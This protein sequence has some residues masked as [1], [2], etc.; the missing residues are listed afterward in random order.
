MPRKNKKTRVE[1]ATKKSKGAFETS[2]EE[3]HLIDIDDFAEELKE[4]S[5]DP[6]E[7][8]LRIID[9]GKALTGLFLYEYEFDMAYRI[10]RAVVTQE[11]GTITI[12]V[13][14]QA[15]KTE[16]M[17]FCLDTLTV[18]LPRM[19]LFI[20]DF[21]DFK[22]GLMCGLFAPQS[23]QVANSLNRCLMR[24]GSENAEAVLGDPDI[25]TGLTSNVRYNLSNGSFIRGQTANVNSKVESQTYH[26][27]VIE[28][29]QDCDDFL[30]QKSIEPMVTATNGLI[31]KVGTTG[32]R[33]SD[34]FLEIQENIKQ[35]RKIKD[36]RMKLHYEYDYKRVMKDKRTQYSIDKKRFH[37]NY[38]KDVM[39][40]KKK[41]GE[42]SDA[43][44]LSYALIWAL[45]SGMFFTDK[46]FAKM[47]NLKLGFPKHIKKEWTIAAG[48][49]IAKDNASTILTILRIEDSKSD[50][51]TEPPIK[52]VI[53]WVDLGGL[54]Y[55]EQHDLLV[56]TFI[57]YNVQVLYADYTGVGKPVVERLQKDIGDYMYIFPYTF[58]RPSK[59]DM[60]TALLLDLQAGRLI[61]PSNKVVRETPEF[62]KF[63]EQALALQKWYQGSYLVAEGLEEFDDYMDSLALGILAGNEEIEAGQ[64][65]VVVTPFNP[66]MQ[67]DQFAVG[68]PTNLSKFGW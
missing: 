46:S 19:A 1:D 55:N 26:V 44:R 2:H 28:E 27:V 32:T 56:E 13:S 47:T 31:I 43:F 66:F 37:L 36:P 29:A 57:E 20:P 49:D 15:G 25:D 18:L 21:E 11:G 34:F 63:K 52:T 40:K 42:H 62:E 61:V 23:D 53:K 16:T 10:I 64:M 35:S 3:F 48:L 4:L 58:S 33:K 5:F 59:S 12:L 8:T 45:D 30:V 51:P 7:M 67:D 54:G 17:A 14:R 60:W 41:W 22:D 39:R 6:H 24:I 9:F 50:D 38:E 65:E 68:N